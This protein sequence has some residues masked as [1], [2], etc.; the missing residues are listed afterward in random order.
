MTADTPEALLQ[1]Y[2][3][4]LTGF[5]LASM[6]YD[7]HTDPSFDASDAVAA[8]NT[9]KRALLDR[10]KAGDE[11]ILRVANT[12]TTA[13]LAQ[14]DASRAE[15]TRLRKQVKIYAAVFNKA[16]SALETGG[17]TTF[18][19]GMRHDLDTQIAATF[20]A[21]TVAGPVEITVSPRQ[22]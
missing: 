3:D 7:T 22:D 6:G 11:A 15:A 17:F 1:A 21:P 14:L 5:E 9:A 13:L 20:D 16:M 8:H 19:G 2:A 12:E 10:I 18:A 4:T